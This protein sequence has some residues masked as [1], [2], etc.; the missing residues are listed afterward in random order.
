MIKDLLSRYVFLLGRNRK[1][2]VEVYLVLDLVGKA[3]VLDGIGG[4]L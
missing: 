2:E 3:R 4:K 1:R